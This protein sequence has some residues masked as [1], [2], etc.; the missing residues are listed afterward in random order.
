M[1]KQSKSKS[2]NRKNHHNSDFYDT[3][4]FFHAVFSGCIFQNLSNPEID[5]RRINV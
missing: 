1:N 5:I 2:K 4:Y 3:R